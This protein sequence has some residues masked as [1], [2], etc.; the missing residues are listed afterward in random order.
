V[1]T[2]RDRYGLPAQGT[3]CEQ[4]GLIVM[5][6]QMTSAAYGRFYNGIYRPLVGA[7]HGHAVDMQARKAKQIAYAAEM[8]RLLE[9]YLRSRAGQTF[10][11][12]G[13]ST[14]VVAVQF[15]RR[16]NLRPVILD[17]AADE[18]AEAQ[19]MEM[20]TIGALVEDWEPG[21]RRFGII[22]MFQ[23]IDHLLDVSA[24]LIKLRAAIAEDG[25]FVV[26]VVDFRASYLKNWSLEMALKID[27]PYA[28]TEATAE[29]Y[30]ARA[31]FSPVRKA[32]SA[33]HHLV[34]YV[35]RP[36]APDPDALPPKEYVDRLFWEMR[37]VQN[38]PRPQISPR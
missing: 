32:Y 37:Y 15:A 21:D 25:L 18:L 12:V 6:P 1:I 17:P 31:G 28:L 30:L 9:P 29:A 14:G 8:E 36:C 5:N 3:A 13:G 38:A 11:D 22:G 10:L 19:A 7:Y 34:A 23:T 35:C 2:H 24:T 33:D 26:D 4:C 16:F 20:E 27:H